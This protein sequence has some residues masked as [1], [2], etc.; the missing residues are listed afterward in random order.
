MPFAWSVHDSGVVT[1]GT[2][3]GDR[4]MLTTTAPACYLEA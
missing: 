4:Y 3:V 1:A 2:V